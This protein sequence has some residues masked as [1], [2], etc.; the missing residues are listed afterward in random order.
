MILI[1]RLELSSQVQMSKVRHLVYAM[2]IPLLKTQM[3]SSGDR[4][5]LETWEKSMQ[6]PVRNQQVIFVFSVGFDLNP[7]TLSCKIHKQIILGLSFMGGLCLS[8]NQ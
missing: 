5:H 6:L 8:L 7:V 4:A 3:L 2:E 1:S